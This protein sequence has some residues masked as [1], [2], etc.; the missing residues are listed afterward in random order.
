MPVSAPGPGA[1]APV[2]AGQLPVV[3]VNRR[4]A[5]RWV[6]GHPWIYQTDVA[7]PG[8]LQ[9]GEIVGVRDGRDRLLGS[10]WYSRAS[11]IAL[12]RLAHGDTPVDEEFFRQRIAAA[13]GLRREFLPGED[14][15]RVVHGEA[16]GL[17]GLVVDRYGDY[18]SVQFLVPGTDQRRDLFT[19]LLVEHFAPAGIV[20]RSDLAVRKLEGLAAEK[21]LLHGSVPEPVVL[22]E[23][24]I[25]LA[26]SLL[27]GQKTGAFLD[28]RE[29]HLVAGRHAR[30]RALDC[31]SYTGGFALQMARR[32]EAVTAVESSAAA[33]GHIRA[34]AA[35][36]GLGNLEVV[37]ASAFDFLRE[38]HDQ[39]RRYDTIV[40]DPPAFAKNRNAVEAGL[41]G[42]R[43]INQRALRLLSPGGLLITCSCSYHVDEPA[44][45]AMLAD[46]AADAHRDVQV[47]ERRGAGR[48]HPVLLALRE[49]RYLKCFVLRAA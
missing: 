23:G 26:I 48:D 35:R 34:N 18:L 44:F 41:R 13:D 25:S 36:N 11:K 20:N 40:L 14:S 4:A 22:R 19:R 31:F 28:Q 10:A 29:N 30:G 47:I 7:A 2:P 9:G 45:E 17:P 43:E 8:N 32:A 1:I 27:E 46:A 24:E 39:G 15:Y 33:C 37:A 42:Y 3:V 49:T 21:G 5:Q 16:D 38:A 6:A 12:R